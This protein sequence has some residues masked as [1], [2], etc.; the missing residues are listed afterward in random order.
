[1]PTL[2]QLRYLVAIAD[3]L[4]FSRAAER[5][6]VTQ[7]TLSAQLRELEM[8]LG[9]VL[10]ERNRARVLPTAAGTEIA[11]RARAVLSE[12]D[13]IRDIAR[14]GDRDR[15]DGVLKLGVVHTV[16]AYLLS[17][18]M[19]LLRQEFPGLR[20][21]VRED[22]PERLL[23]QLGDGVHD[24]LVLPEEPGRSDFETEALLRESLLVV[25]PA[26][27]R[28]A[29]RPAIEPSDLAGETVLTMESWHRL[30]DQIADLCR[31]TGA[32][33]ARDYEG[34]S[35]D[36][37]RQMVA[38]GM[39]IALL[40][41]LYVRSEVMRERLVVARPLSRGAPL[42]RIVLTWRRANPQRER[43]LGLARVMRDAVA[44]FDVKD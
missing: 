41:A 39:G 33:L 35:L 11:R 28:L 17:V 43:F 40:P 34:T 6:N 36:T 29:D 19:P 16:G 9:T 42:R 15:L 14:D 3:T 1:M 5:L 22:R 44:E 24:A 8:R 26:D 13:N 12:I 31:E 38:T 30:H 4:N 20:L 7:P 2:Q 25:L 32:E 27:H 10:F 21:Y 18:A 37:V 23:P